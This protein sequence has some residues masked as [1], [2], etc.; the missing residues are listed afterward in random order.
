MQRLFEPGVSL[1]VH[2][3][4]IG[5]ISMSGLAEFLAARGHSVS[6]CDRKASGLT[7]M[8]AAKGIQIEIGH[9]PAHIDAADVVV[10]TAAIPHEQPELQ[11][12]RAR[13]LPTIERAILLGGVAATYP[14]RIAVAGTHGKTTTTGML[15]VVLTEAG[16]DPAISLGGELDQIGGNV[17]LGGREL[18]LTEAC[19]YVESFLHLSPTIAMILNVEADH[20]DFFRDLTHLKG[21]FARF[22][23]LVPEDGH[24]IAR[25][26]LPNVADAVAGARAGVISFGQGEAADFHPREIRFDRQGM[27]SFTAFAYGRPLDRVELNV[28]G[29]HNILNALAALAAASLLGVDPEVAIAALGRYRGTKRRFERKGQHN[30]VTV[31]DDYAHHPTEVAA[32]IGAAR[33]CPHQRIWCVFQPHTYSR[34]KA[35]LHDFASALSQADR[36]L[37]L[38]I[39]AARERDDGQI[40]AR[41]LALLL[42][43]QGHEAMYI[44]SFAETVDYLAAHTRPGDLVLTM[45]A[46]DVNRI[47]E[48]LLSRMIGVETPG[49]GRDKNP[50]VN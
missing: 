31:I 1:R 41:D 26:E 15:G 2:F 43:E 46:G 8:L 44:P 9:D 32:T 21:A 40:H 50:G 23:R 36:V 13:N 37:I 5:G 35:L 6:G 19:E 38:D 24:I 33:N 47:G 4:G 49:R 29:M 11:A 12:A 30:G 48:M 42:Q 18:F 34:T 17:R 45:G 28:P 16:L 3:I 22:A 7:A 39:Y 27:P 25:T 10:Y 20:P 14:K